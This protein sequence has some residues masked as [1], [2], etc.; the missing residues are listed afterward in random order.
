MLDSDIQLFILFF[1]KP[2]DEINRLFL[3]NPNI[4]WKTSLDIHIMKSSG[5]AN[6]IFISSSNFLAYIDLLSK[7]IRIDYYPTFL[8]IIELLNLNDLDREFEKIFL[9]IPKYNCNN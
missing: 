3:S 7:D 4:E 9:G 2:L 8:K 5:I 1:K 6:K